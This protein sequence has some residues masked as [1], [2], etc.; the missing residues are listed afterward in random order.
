MHPDITLE[1]TQLPLERS[2]KIL[3]VIMDPSLSFH[4]H[5]NYVTDRIDKRNHILKALV[6]LSWGHKE[7]TADLQC[8]GEI[9][10]KLCCT[11]LEHQRDSSFM[12]NTA[13]R[14]ATGIHKMASVDHLHQESHAESQG[15]L[16]HAPCTVPCQ[17]SG[18]GQRLS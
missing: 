12:K 7:T 11:S 6:G 15:P 8:I 3:E 17:L 14:T 16:R 1:G 5:C 18:G 2:P 4:K 13:M 10:R 9:H